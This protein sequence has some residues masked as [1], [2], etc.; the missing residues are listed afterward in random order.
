MS[1]QYG[2]F[3]PLMAETGSGV[4]VTP[5]NFNGFRVLASLLPRRRSTEV[6][7]TMHDVW[8]S[9]GLV[10][11]IYIFRG[12]C[13]VTEFCHVQNSLC[14]QLLLSPIY[15]Q[16]YCTALEQSASAKVCGIVQGM[17]LQNFC[18]GHHLYSTG[19][20]SNWASAH[21]L[22]ITL[23]PQTITPM[24][25]WSKQFAVFHTYQHTVFTGRCS[26]ASAVLGVVIL[27]VRLSVCLTR[28]LWLIQRTSRRYFYTTWKG[29]PS[30]FLPPNSGWWATSSSTFNGRSKW[31]PPLQN[32]LTSTDFRL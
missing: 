13:P 5:A 27:S 20:P 9:P 25:L 16:H 7:Q 12:S 30:S 4:C 32:S 24:P 3:G 22:V 15:C 21:I 18:R 19:R 26:Y 10:H 31:P 14:L 1:P 11:Y 2:N 17:E 6:N 23:L 28:A 8:P 29:N